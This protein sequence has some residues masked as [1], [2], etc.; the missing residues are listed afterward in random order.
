MGVL[1]VPN[2]IA[3]IKEKLEGSKYPVILSGAGISAE[4]GVPTFRGSEGLWNNYRAEELATPEAFE[5]DPELVWNWYNWRRELIGNIQPNRA[6]ESLVELEGRYKDFTII[7]Q[8][9]DGLHS[10]AGS[11]D[12]LTLHGDIWK[13]RC[14]KCGEVTENREVPISILPYCSSTAGGSSTTVGHCG[15]LLRPHIVWFGESLEEENISR[16]FRISEL[17]DIM[18]V[19]GTSGV[20][21]PAA[22]LAGI[23]KNSGAFIVEINTEKT[24]LT[25]ICDVSIVGKAGEVMPRLL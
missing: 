10:L 25:N 13:T 14:T 18:I 2:G 8:N 21:Q 19:V 6:H 12:V 23:A 1:L 16:A 4:S 20:V 17:C 7:T 24:E 3:T 22:S 9:V 15:G 5:R 11:S